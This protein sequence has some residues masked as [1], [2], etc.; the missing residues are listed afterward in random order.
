[1]VA[2]QFPNG[3]TDIQTNPTIWGYDIWLCNTSGK[4][5]RIDSV[6][7]SIVNAT[8]FSGALW[9]FDRCNQYNASVHQVVGGCG[10]ADIEYDYMSATFLSD[11]GAGASVTAAMQS[12]S[13][14]TTP[15]LGPLPVVIPPNQEF[16]VQVQIQGL[17]NPATYTFSFALGVDRAAPQTVATSQPTLV[18]PPTQSWSGD[19]CTAPTMQARMPTTGMF[20]CP[21]T[22]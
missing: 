6:Q 7:V 15:Q 2:Q 18:A 11:A 21:P 16:S 9:A 4:A 17:T 12:V 14:V 3:A 22:S 5:Q 13:Q 1:V 19:N 8:P 20:V 10:G